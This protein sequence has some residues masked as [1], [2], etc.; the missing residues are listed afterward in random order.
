MRLATQASQYQLVTGAASLKA[1]WQ[2]VS[3]RAPPHRPLQPQRIIGRR[4]GASHLGYAYLVKA[5]P[6]F[7]V[8][9]LAP[10]VRTHPCTEPLFPRPLDL[11]DPPR[12]VHRRSSLKKT[13]TRGAYRQPAPRR[14][15]PPQ[16]RSGTSRTLECNTDRRSRQQARGQRLPASRDTLGPFAAGTGDRIGPGP[17]DTTTAAGPLN[18]TYL[19]ADD[20]VGWL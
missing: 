11:T 13:D 3:T 5:V 7:P 4:L 1:G 10:A 20:K 19:S 14:A 2:A 12:V 6:A 15:V 17:V 9:K 18:L 16:G 8:E